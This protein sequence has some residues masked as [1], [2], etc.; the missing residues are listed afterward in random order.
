MVR[1]VAGRGDLTLDPAVSEPA[2]HEDAV[3]PFEHLR[4]VFLDVDG[5]HPL[6]GHADAGIRPG[7]VERLDVADVRILEVRVLADEGD[8]RLFLRI[9]E[10]VEE[11]LP[12]LH[13]LRFRVQA[14]RLQDVLREAL[15]VEQ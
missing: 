14:E 15:A 3:G 9:L 2:G 4:P 12:L 1:R 6:Q 11:L 5:L 7:V 10:L 8:R 13:V